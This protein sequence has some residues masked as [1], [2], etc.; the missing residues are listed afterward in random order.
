MGDLKRYALLA[1]AVLMA[2]LGPALLLGIA[3][4]DNGAM[5]VVYGIA[6]L[7]SVCVGLPLYFWRK[8][9]VPLWGCVLACALIGAVPTGLY[10]T[11]EFR[12]WQDIA[13]LWDAANGAALAGLLG[14]ITGFVFWLLHN[15]FGL[16]GK[17]LAQRRVFIA[18]TAA[19]LSAP[20][21]PA[22]AAGFLFVTLGIVP[23]AYIV[24]LVHMLAP[25]LLAFALVHKFWRVD[26]IS[27]LLA[28][29]VVGALPAGFVLLTAMN[30]ASV[31]S[32]LLRLAAQALNLSPGH[33]YFVVFATAVMG[34]LSGAVFW[35][36]LKFAGDRGGLKKPTAILAAAIVAGI[37]ACLSGGT[38]Q[39]QSCHNMFRDGQRAIATKYQIHLDIGTADWDKVRFLFLQ[40]SGAHRLL[41]QDLTETGQ[42]FLDMCNDGGTNIAG[43]GFYKMNPATKENIYS[44]DIAFYQSRGT[45]EWKP[46]AR[47]LETALESVFPGKWKPAPGNAALEEQK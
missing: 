40:F 23:I 3:E 5:A 9:V 33:E 18:T 26:L 37:G 43:V 34:A 31:P 17:P 25:G 42:R 47:E 20:L 24:A 27:S 46:L 13:G 39:D 32:Q 11:W 21:A 8:T 22:I 29:A 2:P 30:D 44:T 19:F 12:V 16:S 15:L 1:L 10:L 7:L 14:A 36:V 38:A 41:L 4:L 35:L 28:G 6:L 45:D